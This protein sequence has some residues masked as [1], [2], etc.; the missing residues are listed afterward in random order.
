MHLDR[1]TNK[2]TDK[3]TQMHYPRFPLE[4][5]GKHTRILRTTQTCSNISTKI[6]IEL[7]YNIISITIQIVEYII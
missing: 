7:E 6:R 2:Y 3:Q 4:E 5:P 1:H